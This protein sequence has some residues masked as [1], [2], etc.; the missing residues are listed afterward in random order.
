MDRV[1]PAAT[2]HAGAG[3]HAP[4]RPVAR[5]VPALLRAAHAGPT[6]AVTVA[7]GLLTL[8]A[9]L[10]P[11]RALLLVGAV[12]TGQLTIGWSNDLLDA[13]RDLASG[14]LDKPL[15]TG[16]LDARLVRGACA[17]GL[18][19]TLVL[20]LGA[21]GAAGAVQLITVAAGWAY[22]L[23]LK[24]TPWSWAPYAVAFGGLP[25]AVALVPG[26][27]GLPWWVVAAGAVV[28]VGAH[29][30]NVV[31]DLADDAATGVHGLPHRLGA[32]RSVVAAVALLAAGSVL[33]AVAPGGPVDAV[34]RAALAVVGLL[35]AAALGG[36][37]RTPFRAAMLIALVDV[38]LVGWSL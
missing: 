3:V 37:G 16:E 15:A 21:G 6:L 18:A 10:S 11:A 1:G 13:R 35:A 28:G 36:R 38:L 17:V 2:T 33:V 25:L 34:G 7:V 19:L 26:G 31:P 8:P 29:L 5:Q 14:R 27:D 4:S 12:L 23:G 24:S 9:G 22:N 32:R 30:V 20:S